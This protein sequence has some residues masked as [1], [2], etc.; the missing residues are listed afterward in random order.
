MALDRGAFPARQRVGAF[1]GDWQFVAGIIV[2][3]IAVAHLPL[4][5]LYWIG[6]M[7]PIGLNL[8]CHRT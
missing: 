1:A 2:A 7:L 3:I 5:V 8:L 4:V 6:S